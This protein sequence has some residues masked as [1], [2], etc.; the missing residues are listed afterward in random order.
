MW[1]AIGCC[2][3]KF[4]IVTATTKTA[5]VL[6]LRVLCPMQ[7]SP[8]LDEE[9]YSIRPEEPG[10]ILCCGLGLLAYDLQDELG[11]TERPLAFM[12]CFVFVF[13]PPFILL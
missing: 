3:N 5:A 7:N 4:S 2:R 6:I 13:F 8:E 11:F 1:L 12:C 10:Y 9:G